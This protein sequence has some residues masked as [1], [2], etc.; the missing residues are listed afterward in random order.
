[1]KNKSS[2]LF[3]SIRFNLAQQGKVL[4]TSLCVY[5][6]LI[7]VSEITTDSMRSYIVKGV[8]LGDTELYSMA[9]LLTTE[10]NY[11]GIPPGPNK[12]QLFPS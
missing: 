10:S 4:L 8:T 3:G 6:D 1:M 5:Q 12:T 7:Y 11:C 9:I 2:I